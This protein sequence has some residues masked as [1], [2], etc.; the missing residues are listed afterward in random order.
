[1][2]MIKESFTWM[3]FFFL[4][5]LNM[6]I[7]DWGAEVGQRGCTYVNFFMLSF[8]REPIMLKIK[9]ILPP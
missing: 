7:R 3:F 4:A 9:S 8:W 6:E 5:F 1:M 2:Q